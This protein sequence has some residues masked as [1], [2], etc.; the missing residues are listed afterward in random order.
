MVY[1]FIG[2]T[3]LEELAKTFIVYK[4]TLF[5]MVVSISNQ[6]EHVALM[7]YGRPRENHM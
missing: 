6:V 4:I 3:N 7:N 5:G 1:G 2:V